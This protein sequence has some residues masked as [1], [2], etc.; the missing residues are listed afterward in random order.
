MSIDRTK[1]VVLGHA[2]QQFDTIQ[3]RDYLNFC[4][5][6]S[7]K[8]SDIYGF[9]LL[10]EAKSYFCEDIFSGDFDFLGNVTA[11]W[12]LKYSGRNKIDDFDKWETTKRLFSEDGI[13]LCANKLNI[14]TWFLDGRSL[15]RHIGFLYYRDIILFLE[16]L[17]LDMPS[18]AST[19]LV[20]L[21]NQ[22][23][24]H[25]SV[26]LD[27][28]SFMRKYMSIVVDK[29]KSDQKL[30]SVG[31][32]LSKTRPLGYIS[33]LISALWY[34]N[35]GSEYTILENE[36][37]RGDWYSPSRMSNRIFYSRY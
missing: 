37:M 32:D 20:P 7:L 4:N 17:D 22:I 34:F 12:N 24:S 8:R 25:R 14:N 31:N 15:L 11:S 16:K 5:L 21:S 30:F 36:R 1:I 33:E 3:K 13:I 19:V 23:I 27:K 10:A 18:K 29:F 2:Q 9:D 26:F 28:L 6:N 35:R